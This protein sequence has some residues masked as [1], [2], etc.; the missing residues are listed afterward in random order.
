MS[1]VRAI[2]AAHASL[3][4]GLVAAVEVITGRAGVLRALSN[5]GLGAQDIRAA[6]A[7]ALDETGAHVVFTDLPAGS[8]ALAARRLLRERAG[9]SLVTGVNLPMLLEF[10]VRDDESAD[11]VAAAVARG[12]EHVHLLASDVR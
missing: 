6:I 1:E 11:A 10:A 4:E 3:A 7:G 5:T 9:L 12:R 8:C 2:V